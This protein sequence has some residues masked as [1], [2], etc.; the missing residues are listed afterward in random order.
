MDKKSKVLVAVFILALLM[1][2]G[3][4][5]YRY[6]STGDFLID[7]SQVEAEE[8]IIDEAMEGETVIEEESTEAVESE[9]EA[10]A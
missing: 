7:E 8:E 1:A 9:S 2:L 5:Y 3:Y 10:G 6:V 4:S